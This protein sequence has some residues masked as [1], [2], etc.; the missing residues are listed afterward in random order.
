MSKLDGTSS[1]TSDLAII[2]FYI[3]TFACS[4]GAFLTWIPLICVLV[5]KSAARS[6]GAELVLSHCRWLQRTILYGWLW[7][8][9]LVIV[10]IIVIAVMSVPTSEITALADSITADT[11]ALTPSTMLAVGIMIGAVVIVSLWQTYRI[12]RGI[13][14]VANGNR[15]KPGYC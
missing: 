12:L 7:A 4:M 2:G 13:Y 5:A 3:L 8:T 14:N 15:P 10:G 11:D 6:Q 9:L 1:T